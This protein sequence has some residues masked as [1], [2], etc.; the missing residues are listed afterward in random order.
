MDY[1]LPKHIAIVMDGNGRWAESRGLARIEGHKAG[2]QS[3]KAVIRCCLEKNIPCLSL[4]AFSSENWQRPSDEVDF[5]MALFIDAL[6]K[7]LDE[8]K[9]HGIQI[10]FTGDRGRLSAELQR[11][12]MA[13]EEQTKKNQKMTLN[14]VVNYGGKWDIVTAAKK[15]AQAVIDK[16]LELAQIDEQVFNRF[17][18][19]DDL[20]EPDLFIRT[21]G[22]LR[23]SNFFLWQLAYTEFYFT[24]I[25]W[26]DFSPEEFER[27]LASFSKRKRRFGQ[28][29]SPS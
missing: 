29:V 17:I 11:Q 19:T 28:V 13:A 26:P 24:E 2:V 25:H 16:K 3:V 14:I 9:Q 23:I 5:L 21:S 7:E 15:M 12:M 4:F 20:L 6:R 22:E 8:L 1:K 18:S 10:R 27:A